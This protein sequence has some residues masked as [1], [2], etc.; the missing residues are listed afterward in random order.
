MQLSMVTGGEKVF[1]SLYLF[2]TP[3]SILTGNKLYLFS[4]FQVCFALYSNW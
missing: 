2:L 4:P 1:K 3:K